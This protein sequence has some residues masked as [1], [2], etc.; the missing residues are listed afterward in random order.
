[1]GG[2]LD[3][4]RRGRAEAR[5][6]YGPPPPFFRKKFA[7]PPRPAPRYD[8]EQEDEEE[9]YYEP[10]PNPAPAGV[11]GD[12]QAIKDL[13][14]QS[15]ALQAEN[16]RLIAELAALQATKDDA[17]SKLVAKLKWELKGS[18]ESIESCHN[19]MGELKYQHARAMADIRSANAD[20][21]V[22]LTKS[23]E[24]REIAEQACADLREEIAMLEQ[25]GRK[26][27][28]RGRS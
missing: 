15:E 23:E 4:Y 8:D 12:E 26:R 24:R 3:A 19:Q 22:E 20:L 27:Q 6:K 13:I 16:D 11:D 5:A 1:M 9:D 25:E 2:F 7:K 14:A 21:K 10:D 18:N 17:D 28:G